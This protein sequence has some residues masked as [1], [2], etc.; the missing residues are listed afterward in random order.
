MT[1]PDTV[2]KD[3]LFMDGKF[4][5]YSKNN[6]SFLEAYLYETNSS[7]LGKIIPGVQNI[8]A[9]SGYK[10][11]LLSVSFVQDNPTVINE[12]KL[13]ISATEILQNLYGKNTIAPDYGQVPFF[14]D[15]FSY[16]QQK[17]PGVYFFLGGSNFEKGVIAMNHSPNFQVDEES[18]RTGVRS[19]SSLIIERLNR[20]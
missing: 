11:K 6:E 5:I 13:T 2:F 20:N 7:N 14:N 12:E 10:E 16:F 8:I 9:D 4:D 3:Y 17:I 15:D 18:I 19:F 1:N